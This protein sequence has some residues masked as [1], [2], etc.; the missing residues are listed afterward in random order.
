MKAIHKIIN[1]VLALSIML[2]MVAIPVTANSNIQLV[3]DGNPVVFTDA[4]PFVE[5]GRTLVPVRSLAEA[6]EATV[7][8]NG[9]TNTVTLTKGEFSLSLKIGAYKTAFGNGKETINKD[10]DT[11]AIVINGRTY[12]PARFVGYG[13]GYDVE[14][15][16]PV[17]YYTFTNKQTTDFEVKV[18]PNT[19]YPNKYPHNDQ[20]FSYYDG[21][22]D[23]KIVNGDDGDVV[24]DI[25]EDGTIR[26]NI[27]GQ[28]VYRYDG[29]AFDYKF[30][31]ISMIFDSE[32]LNIDIENKSPEENLKN[33]KKVFEDIAREK[34]EEE[35]T[36]N[37]NVLYLS[38]NTVDNV[39]NISYDSNREIFGLKK[40]NKYKWVICNTKVMT[41]FSN[42]LFL[43]DYNE[44]INGT[45]HESIAYDGGS[46]NT[47]ML[48]NTFLG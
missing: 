10:M 11:K 5:N 9:E 39:A 32:N 4:Y 43:S 47:L 37:Y 38:Y 36:N 18:D 2:I 26:K 45:K 48:L 30:T 40:Y 21:Y 34:A 8:W 15:K 14:W 25:K 13:L 7:D 6:M 29:N 46:K 20:T 19:K 31:P 41:D 28:I 12:I 35:I 44:Y 42:Y 3:V 27:Y 1:L 33:F 24:P 23:V 22:G 16:D 17:V